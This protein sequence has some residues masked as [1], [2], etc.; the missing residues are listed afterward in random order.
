[1]KIYTALSSC[2]RFLIKSCNSKRPS[3]PSRGPLPSTSPRHRKPRSESGHGLLR[4]GH[5]LRY[6]QLQIARP[7]SS[8]EFGGMYRSWNPSR[9]QKAKRLTRAMFRIKQQDIKSLWML[10]RLLR[11]R[12][13]LL[14]VQKESRTKTR[15]QTKYCRN[16]NHFQSHRSWAPRFRLSVQSLLLLS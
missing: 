3:A 10:A 6:R 2:G 7:S 16:P 9:F 13:R 14:K 12:A 1:M 15:P 8:P 5:I 11:T 4:K